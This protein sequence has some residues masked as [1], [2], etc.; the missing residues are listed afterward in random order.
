MYIFVCR[1]RRRRRMCVCVC[2]SL[3]ELFVKKEGKKERK[4][5][6]CVWVVFFQSGLGA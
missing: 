1:R 4:S 5:T 2:F 6:V 3:G